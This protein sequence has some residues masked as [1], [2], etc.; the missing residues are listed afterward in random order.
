MGLVILFVALGI[1]PTD[2]SNFHAPHW[3]VGA[4]GL[5]FFLAG[6]AIL[7]GPPPGA[8]EASRTTWRTFLLGLGVV[9]ALAAVFNWIAF[10]PGPR[11]FS[12]GISIPFVAISGPQSEW[13]GRI[14][15]GVAAGLIDLFLVW[16]I[17]RG[18][19]DLLGRDR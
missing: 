8:P 17:V 16:V 19:R 11:S 12:G 18:L 15:F 1:I 7:V 13:S 3:V 14:A 4:A 5:A 2:E 9:G 6:L 10:G